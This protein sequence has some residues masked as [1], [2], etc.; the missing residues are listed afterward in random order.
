M[1]FATKLPRVSATLTTGWELTGSRWGNV[2][3]ETIAWQTI[4]ACRLNLDRH[5]DAFSWYGSQLDRSSG[6][7]DNP[8]GLRDLVNDGCIVIEAYTGHLPPSPNTAT[9]E[10]GHPLIL[11]VTDALLDY[12]AMKCDV[13]LDT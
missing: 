4:N 9:D 10:S 12:V 13:N 1:D 5:G 11:R 3:A 7:V 2:E 6:T 8:K